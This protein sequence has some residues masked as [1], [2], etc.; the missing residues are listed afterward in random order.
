MDKH[1]Q[2]PVWLCSGKSGSIRKHCGLLQIAQATVQLLRHTE[3]AKLDSLLAEE[4]G[5][6]QSLD[7][8]DDG[9]SCIGQLTKTLDRQSKLPVAERYVYVNK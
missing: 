1:S 2:L 9:L 5:L 8:D 4:K 6:L 3:L 7:D